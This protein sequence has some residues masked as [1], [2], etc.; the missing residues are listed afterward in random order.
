[1]T[2]AL[3]LVGREAAREMTELDLCLEEYV[4]WLSAQ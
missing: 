3:P 1:M 2:L 4:D